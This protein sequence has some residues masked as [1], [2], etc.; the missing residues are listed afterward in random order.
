M[1]KI[2]LIEI[3]GQ[4]Q[5]V[6]LRYT[7]FQHAKEN[8]LKGW[9]RNEP[10]GTVLCCLQDKSDKVDKFVCWLK[11]EKSLAG[12]SDVKVTWQDVLSEYDDFIIK[13]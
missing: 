9:I 11:E 4:V 2:A 1:S 5:G 8:N 13:Y 7:V 3:S 6:G 10:H 12:I